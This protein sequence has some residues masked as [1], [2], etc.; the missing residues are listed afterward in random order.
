LLR[1]DS[2]EEDKGSVLREK[3]KSFVHTGLVY[4][5]ECG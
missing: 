1:E 4:V 5:E 2:G 3:L